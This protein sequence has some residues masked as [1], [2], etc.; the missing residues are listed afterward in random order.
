MPAVRSFRDAARGGLLDDPK[1]L[2]NTEEQ[3]KDVLANLSIMSPSRS[4]QAASPGQ[5]TP[6]AAT[7]PFRPIPSFSPATSPMIPTNV[8]RSSSNIV[9]EYKY[10]QMSDR[11]RNDYLSEG[12]VSREE[13]SVKK[14]RQDL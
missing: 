6:Q 5:A 14:T 9:M 13:S 4:F 7:A 1:S 2:Q 3:V 11:K 10:G 8:Q 12:D